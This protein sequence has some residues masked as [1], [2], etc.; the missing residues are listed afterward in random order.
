VTEG[1]TLG[2]DYKHLKR[3]E[4]RWFNGWAGLL[5]GLVIGFAVAL[6]LRLHDRDVASAATL[7]D[8]AKASAPADAPEVFSFPAILEQGEAGSAQ[9]EGSAGKAPAIAAGP[10]VL[11]VGWF[12]QLEEAEKVHA[13]LAQH[14]V[15][16]R[17]QR[18]EVGDESWYRLRIGPIDTA[19]EIRDI[20]AR[21]DEV[22]IQ[23]TPVTKGQWEPVR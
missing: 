21:L 10:V 20:R 12:R 18:L 19:E 6:G 23:A 4:G 3:T 8:T 5:I 2:R 1:R 22:Q 13:R 9:A 7:D 17:M 14:G 15:S 16:A 11:Q